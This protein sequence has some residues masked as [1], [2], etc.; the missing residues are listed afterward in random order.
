MLA[1]SKAVRHLQIAVLLLLHGWTRNAGSSPG[2]QF[3]VIFAAAREL[4]TVARARGVRTGAEIE[5]IIEVHLCCCSASKTGMRSL[6][7]PAIGL[8]PQRSSAA[9]S[10]HHTLHAD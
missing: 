8:C 6:D 9:S 10:I 7:V 4:Q 1:L 3:P 5:A 2:F